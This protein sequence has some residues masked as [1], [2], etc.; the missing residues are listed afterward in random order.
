[1]YQLYT[2]AKKYNTKKLY[3][4]YPRTESFGEDLSPFWYQEEGEG[5]GVIGYDVKS[6]WCVLFDR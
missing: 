3:L 5:L 6:D 4:I 1:M 2:Y